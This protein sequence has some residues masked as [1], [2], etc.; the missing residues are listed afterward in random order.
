MW[1]QT[2]NGAITGTVTDVQGAMI[3]NAA[4]IARN[5][6][7]GLTYPSQCNAE[8][9]YVLSSLPVGTYELRVSAQGF[10]TSIHGGITLDVGQRL[11]V[12]AQLTVGSSSEEV[13]VTAE[14]PLLQAEESSLGTVIDSRRIEELPLNGRQPFT[15][16]KLAPGVQNI[17]NDSSGFADSG[18]QGF[19]RLRINGGSYLGNQFLLDGTMDTIPNIN[20]ISVVPMADSITEFRVETS[21]PKAEYGQT[22]GG[23]VNLATRA[24]ENT[25]HGSAYEF[26]RN[27]MFDSLNRFATTQTKAKLRYNQFGGTMG[28]PV[29]LPHLYDGH[30]RTFFFFGYEQYHY[31]TSTLQYTTVPT[32]LQRKGDFSQTFDAKGALIPI[33]DPDTTAPNPQGNGYVRSPFAGNVITHGLDP[34]SQKILQYMPLPNTPPSNAFTNTNNFV[35]TAPSTI[36]QDAIAIRGDHK[37]NASDSLFVRYAGNLNTSSTFGY[38]LGVADPQARNDYRANHNIALGETHVFTPVLLNEFRFSILRQ[39]LTFRAPSVGGD[40]PT[41]LGMSDLLPNTEFPSVQASGMMSLGYSVSGSPSNGFR[42]SNV[43]QAADALIWTRGRHTI[44]MGGEFHKTQF[45]TSAQVYPSGEFSFSGSFTDNPQSPSGTGVGWADFLLGQV[46]S[47][48]QNYSQ[49]F[50]TKSWEFGVYTQDDYKLA[51]TLTLNLG[52]RYELSAPPVERHNYFSTFDPNTINPQTE[53]PGVMNYAGVNGAPTT[54]VDANYTNFSP[55]FGFAWTPL[56]KTVMRGG[57]GIIFNPVEAADIHANS[58]DALGFAAQTT[59]SSSDPYPAFQFSQGPSSLLQPIGASGGA[60]AYRG[61]SVYVQS[62]QAPSAYNE[63]WNL[64]IQ[65]ELSKGWAVTASYVGSH[66]VHLIG[67]NLN[68]NQLDPGYYAS[69]GSKLQNQVPNPFYGQIKTGSLAKTTIT[70]SQALLPFPD[71]LGVTTIARHGVG[72]IYHALD[73]MAERRF[74]TGATILFSYAK[75]KLIDDGSN[76]DAGESTQGLN[77]RY[78]IYNPHADRSLD[79]Y[80]VSQRATLSGTWAIHVSHPVPAWAHQIVNGWQPNGILTLSTGFPL[81]VT[82]ANNFTSISI[83]NLVGN[84]KLP[85]T[86]RSVSQWFNTAAFQ[87]PANYV[88]GNAPF[89]LSS[90]R[91]PGYF[92]TDLS[93]SK[94]FDCWEKSKLQFRAEAFNVFNHPNLSA[95][96]TSFSP[97]SA[98]VNTNSLF[99][100]ITSALAP[101]YVQFGA[102]LKW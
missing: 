69:Y 86:T 2:T 63:Q 27:D 101:R 58:N 51:D 48:Q 15:L 85:R 44:Q 84:P 16:V 96:N 26:L 61:Q 60:G 99:G 53:M 46:A 22:T 25:P 73:L 35:G 87:N 1:S 92:N 81:R 19:S 75:S 47:G 71:Y 30:D 4:V 12:D 83:P 41:Q 8:G 102:H 37:I 5:T 70:Q 78:G 18:N 34:L 49:M 39:Y 40:L 95:P 67:G 93:L 77:S 74:S 64:S 54:F 42:V 23:I 38:G 72:T 13:T 88:V 66:G 82:G 32:E 80:D 31:I 94:S 97:N 56:K 45:N 55:R 98:G 100:T 76:E 7:T 29:W 20:E 91:S 24:G 57:Y 6:G 52:V 3:P 21:I 79:P 17:T 33:F 10:Q 89:M 28:G 59:F 9:V 90:V 50:S 68:L 36:F 43:Y 14:T 65:Q 62:R 11:R